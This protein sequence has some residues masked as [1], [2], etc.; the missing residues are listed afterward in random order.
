[1]WDSFEYR[2]PVGDVTGEDV[3]WVDIT[4]VKISTGHW[5]AFALELADDMPRPQEDPADRWIAFGVVQ[6]ANGDGA[7]D[8]RL[9]IDNL[10]LGKHRTWRTDL[11]SGRTKSEVMP[12]DG[13][14]TMYPGEGDS[15][16]RASLGHPRT[17]DELVRAFPF[18]A[19]ASTIEDGRVVAT[20]Y[21]PDTGWLQEGA[22]PEVRLELEGPT[23]ATEF[24]LTGEG[25]VFSVIHE[26]VITADGKIAF[27]TG[28][29]TR[30]GNVTIEPDKLRVSDLVA[31]E[32]ACTDE[33]AEADAK[34]MAVLGAGEINYSL[35][36]A[37]LQLWAG[38]QLIQFE[39]DFEPPG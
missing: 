19:W 27:D 39:S 36:G 35:T 3:A 31:T 21:A 33:M 4:E 9:G 8:V 6:D 24:E 11:A 1:M 10:P 38:E 20:D 12:D 2:D 34:T 14:S 13:Y 26:L 17:F 30:V 28:C 22:P 7:A 15:W 16:D 29:N 23:W 37:V 25:G 18:Y 32:N 5:M